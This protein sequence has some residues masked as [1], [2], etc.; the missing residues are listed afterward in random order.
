MNQGVQVS[1]FQANCDGRIGGKAWGHNGF[2]GLKQRP[3][4]ASGS[5]AD[6]E[7]DKITGE[8]SGSFRNR[9]RSLLGTETAG[10]VRFRTM[11]A[12][13]NGSSIGGN[14]REVSSLKEEG[15]DFVASP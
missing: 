8:R 10:G 7:V 4:S 15:D 3:A 11:A 12:G 13:E 5:L 9:I 2:R 1:F 14:Q 6:K